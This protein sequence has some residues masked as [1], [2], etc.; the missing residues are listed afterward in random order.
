MSDLTFD[1]RGDLVSALKGLR[2][3]LV[4]CAELERRLTHRRHLRP[5]YRELINRADAL[6][7]AERALNLRIQT[8][9]R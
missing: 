4:D 6:I 5:D 9:G 1:T 2:D 3:H 8:V 7:D